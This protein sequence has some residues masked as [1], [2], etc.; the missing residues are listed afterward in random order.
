MGRINHRAAKRRLSR[1]I[2]SRDETRVHITQVEPA[3]EQARSLSLPQYLLTEPPQRKW[4]IGDIESWGFTD[5][6]IHL[7]RLPVST[8]TVRANDTESRIWWNRL[9]DTERDA[10]TAYCS[11]A[12]QRTD[13]LLQTGR[14][15]VLAD[16][17]DSALSKAPP[18]EVQTFYRTVF[19]A[20]NDDDPLDRHVGRE[21]PVGAAIDFPGYLTAATSHHYVDVPD[22]A[23]TVMLELRAAEGVVLGERSPGSVLLARKT[24]W[25]VIDRKSAADSGHA[26]PTVYLVPDRMVPTVRGSGN[27]G[28]VDLSEAPF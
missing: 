18:R 13:G 25:R 16:S 26:I 15:P 28:F 6:G 7:S 27:P 20:V 17:L 1:W 21:Y 5:H 19:C 24:R 3:E 14:H 11:G 10:V 9:G 4:H 22:A 23:S 2:S 12:S 8:S